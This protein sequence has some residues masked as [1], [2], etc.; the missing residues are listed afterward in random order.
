MIKSLFTRHRTTEAWDNYQGNVIFKYVQIRLVASNEPL[1][2]RGPLS[3]WLRKKHCT[4][5][6]DTFDDN[7]CVWSCHAIYKWHDRG[8]ENQVE[9]RNL[10]AALNLAREYY[11]DN[12]LKRKDVRPAKRVGFEGISKYHNLNLMLYEPKEDRGEDV[13]F[14]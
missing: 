5:A 9:K 3:D 11:S 6:L 13:G 10:K 8:E 7:L 14:T 12:T 1:I 2:D 4:Y